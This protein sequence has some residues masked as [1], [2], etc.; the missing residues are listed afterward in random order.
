MAS[1]SEY[2]AGI[3]AGGTGRVGPAT[4]TVTATGYVLV[5]G[6]PA[7]LAG[8]AGLPLDVYSLA[9]MVASEN[10]SASSAT[11]LA[12]AEVARNKAAQRSETVTELL[13]RS[14]IT[15]ADGRYSEQAAGKWAS[16]RLDPNGRHVAA[17]TFALGEGSNVFG[18]AIDFF[19]P[20]AQ[21]K[22][23]Q[24][25]H[26]LRQT[27]EEYIAA[28]A[29]E[30]LQ[31][32]GPVDGVN[33]YRLMCFAPPVSGIA[34]TAAAYQALMDGRLG[35]APASSSSGPQL[36][37]GNTSPGWALGAGAIAAAGILALLA[38]L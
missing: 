19:D 17:A 38:V 4:T 9:R 25:T 20:S 18:D 8:Q 29:A 15:I 32:I 12:L 16:T 10:G 23:Q 6:D 22:G 30:G 14:S 37:A 34:D 36:D 26:V 33:P 5:T 28:R 27:S 1:A 7:S 35:K 24:G 31:W 11:L 21:D 2:F 13:T 3:D